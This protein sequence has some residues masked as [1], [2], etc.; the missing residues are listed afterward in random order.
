MKPS[1]PRPKRR[2]GC[3]DT[4]LL[5]ARLRDLPANRSEENSSATPRG[6]VL[7]P[8]SAAVCTSPRPRYRS[9]RR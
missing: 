8:W 2:S 9:S 1:G 6:P 7:T 3:D 4:A 5:V